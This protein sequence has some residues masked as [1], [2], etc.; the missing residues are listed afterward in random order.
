MKLQLCCALAWVI[1]MGSAVFAQ[2]PEELI[3]QAEGDML[4]KIYGPAVQKLNKAAQ[5]DRNNP[6]IYYLLGQC[7]SLQANKNREAI[8]NFQKAVELD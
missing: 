2:T 7:Y 3:R 6:K 4:S 8:Q 5:A 1:L